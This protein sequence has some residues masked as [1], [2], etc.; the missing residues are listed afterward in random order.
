MKLSPY[1]VSENFNPIYALAWQADELLIA[2]RTNAAPPRASGSKKCN[3]K[4]SQCFWNWPA[5]RKDP[6]WKDFFQLSQAIQERLAAGF[7]LIA[8]KNS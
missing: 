5:S 4:T 2:L 8:R 6:I 3:L 7:E 1:L